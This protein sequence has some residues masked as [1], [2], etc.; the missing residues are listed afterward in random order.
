MHAITAWPNGVHQNRDGGVLVHAITAWPNGVHQNGE[1]RVGRVGSSRD[2]CGWEVP[3]TR[4]GSVRVVLAVGVVAILGV[5]ALADD[6]TGRSSDPA[7]CARGLG[8][9]AGLVAVDPVTGGLRWERVAGTAESSVVEDGVVVVSQADRWAIG[10][11]ASTGEVRWCRDV[12]AG[13]GRGIAGTSGTVAMVGVD[14]EVVGIDAATGEERWRTGGFADG[15]LTLSAW[16]GLLW[17]HQWRSTVD[18]VIRDPSGGVPTTLSPTVGL[19][20]LAPATGA[21]VDGPPGASVNLSSGEVTEVGV[22]ASTYE[23]PERVVTARDPDT[24]EV[25]WEAPLP[26]VE[27]EVIGDVVVTLE[28]I[29]A[30]GAPFGRGARLSAFAVSDGSRHWQVEVPVPASALRGAAGLVLVAFGPSVTALDVATGEV[31]WTA[32][33]GSPG[34]GGDETEPGVFGSF[35]GGDPVVGLI[36][37]TEPSRD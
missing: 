30:A 27:V 18:T 14:G 32:D 22:S 11:D 21:R 15:E 34:Q 4:T 31:A 6:G 13:T 17:V 3:V 23:Q 16:R 35:G 12:V 36:V 37:A 20:A 26:G 29:D 2:D 10:V 9:P 33:H 25:R 5:A 8:G 1:R 7:V 28:Q 19:T 24:G